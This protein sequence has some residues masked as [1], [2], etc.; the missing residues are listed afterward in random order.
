MSTLLVRDIDES[1][2]RALKKRA[3]RHGRSAEGEHRAILAEA[4]ARPTRRS[5]AEVLR[6]MPDVGADADF[7]RQQSGD[8]EARG[9]FD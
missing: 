5:L 7:E 9:V 3:G 2:V 4:L 1:L 6:A 8:G